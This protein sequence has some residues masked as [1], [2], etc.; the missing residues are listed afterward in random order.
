MKPVLNSTR[1]KVW[2]VPSNADLKRNVGTD[3]AYDEGIERFA[4]FGNGVVSVSR[5]CTISLA[6]ME[7]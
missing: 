4:H 3:S 7:S 5:P 6:I 1:H 2:D